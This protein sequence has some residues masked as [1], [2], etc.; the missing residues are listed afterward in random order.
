M[1]QRFEVSQSKIKKWRMCRY[2]YHCRYVEHLKRKVKARPLQFGTMVHEMLEAHING[3]DPF[4][5]LDE[6]QKSQGKMFA[7]EREMY[8]DIIEDIR[9]IMTAYYSY[10]DEKSLKYLPYKGK[11]A[12]HEFNLPINE[13]LSFVGKIDCFARTPNKLRWIVDHKTFTR[14]PSDDDRWRNLQ[15][16]VYL[17]ACE[18]LGMKPF[19]GMLWNYVKSKAPKAPEL[20]KAGGLSIRNIDTLPSVVLSVIEEH[21]LNV[22]DNQ[23]LLSRAER[24]LP[25]YFFR[26]YTPVNHGVR[27]MIFTDFVDTATEVMECH[28]R[29]KDRNIDRHCSW[30]DYEPICRAELTGGDADFV[31][32]REYTNGEEDD[33][34]VETAS[35]GDD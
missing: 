25:N 8:G 6:F 32:E 1:T 17:T 12:E 22:E 7:A 5:K 4:E 13:E 2:A 24:N 30:C 15:S 23:E 26:V 11:L 10:Y 21:G 34:E 3:D 35:G 31:R 14:A 16:S 33:L 18:M 27:E 28:G 19:D 29:K 9:L 20:L